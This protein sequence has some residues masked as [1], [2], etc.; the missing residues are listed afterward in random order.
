MTDSELLEYANK[1]ASLLVDRL[2][3]DFGANVVRG[4]EYVE[5]PGYGLLIEKVTISETRHNKSTGST[6]TRFAMDVEVRRYES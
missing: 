1:N 2:E 6:D 4:N 5:V 3:K